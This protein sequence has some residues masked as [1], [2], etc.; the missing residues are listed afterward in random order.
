MFKL[1][2][3]QIII[4]NGADIVVVTGS[5][6]VIEGFCDITD[7]DTYISKLTPSSGTYGVWEATVVGKACPG[8]TVGGDLMI[9]LSFDI[10]KE[11]GGLSGT[12]FMSDMIPTAATE[13][14]TAAAIAAGFARHKAE[15]P[16]T[17]MYFDITSTG[18][19]LNIVQTSGPYGLTVTGMTLKGS[20]GTSA[21]AVTETTPAVS[22][23]GQANQVEASVQLSTYENRNPY[24][25]KV[26]GGDT[27]DMSATY[28][29]YIVA[30]LSD[31]INWAPH[32]GLG[33]GDANT[34]AQYGYNYYDIFINAADTYTVSD[35]DVFVGGGS[36][37]F[38]VDLTPRAPINVAAAVSGILG[39]SVSWDAP[40]TGIPPNGYK[41][42]WTHDGTNYSANASNTGYTISVASVSVVSGINVTSTSANGASSSVASSPATVTPVDNPPKPA[43]SAH[44]EGVASLGLSVP[45][46]PGYEVYTEWDVTNGSATPS[47]LSVTSPA[48][49]Q[50]IKVVVDITPGATAARARVRI[51]DTSSGLVSEWSDWVVFE[52]AVPALFGSTPV[53]ASPPMSFTVM[54]E[55]QYLAPIGNRKLSWSG[56]VGG[57]TGSIDFPSTATDYIEIPATSVGDTL[58]TLVL[59]SINAITATPIVTTIVSTVA[60][61]SS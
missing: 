56:G 23:T 58:G 61:T 9:T 57:L 39:V 1:G 14:D 15:F 5:S 37:T 55:D 52:Q 30:T 21:L 10:T 20:L 45:N 33:H 22:P 41:V 24:R 46:V 48:A 12:S 32:E 44:Y 4:N 6:L 26:N 17:D 19:T 16:D 42:E 47:A 50:P 11:G 38:P 36:G 54:F 49:G 40:T 29:E 2:M 3:K 25:I 60:A 34:S 59:T 35:I 13:T 31:S 8:L 53:Y 27:V 51:V 18:A 43:P 7:D 28:V